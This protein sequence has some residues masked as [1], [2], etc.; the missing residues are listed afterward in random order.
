MASGVLVCAALCNCNAAQPLLPPRVRGC[1][2]V[3]VLT[4][5]APAK[6]DVTVAPNAAADKIELKA[7]S[8]DELR[9]AVKPIKVDPAAAVAAA[10]APS[11]AAITPGAATSAA[12][13][14]KGAAGKPGS[15][16]PQQ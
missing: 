6:Q 2:L 3:Y 4:G 13:G 10:P 8:L 7:M 16:K 9:A 5:F 11:P 12:N 14:A 15:G 1:G